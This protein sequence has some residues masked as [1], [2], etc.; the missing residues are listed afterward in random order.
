MHTWWDVSTH[1]EHLHEM[2]AME[3]SKFNHWFVSSRGQGNSWQ[4]WHAWWAWINSV[5][6]PTWYKMWVDLICI[7]MV[8]DWEWSY[9]HVWSR[10][11]LMPD[12]LPYLYIPPPSS[13]T[14]AWTTAQGGWTATLLLPAWSLVATKGRLVSELQQGQVCRNRRKD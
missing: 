1:T 4:Q 11:S 12:C 3:M 6:E 10:V 9:T 7:Y 2:V 5:S 8:L 14:R 13:G